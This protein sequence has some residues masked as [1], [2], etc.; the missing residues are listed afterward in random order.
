MLTAIKIVESGSHAK[1]EVTKD[2]LAEII[3]PKM[4]EVKLSEGILAFNS[5]TEVRL[6]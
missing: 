3:G 4:K 6:G 5:G 1:M 2:N